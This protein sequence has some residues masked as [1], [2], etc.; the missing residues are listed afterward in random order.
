MNVQSCKTRGL[1]YAVSIAYDSIYSHRTD[2]L[3]DILDIY[4][5]KSFTGK[6]FLEYELAHIYDNINDE[7]NARKYMKLYESHEEGMRLNPAINGVW[8]NH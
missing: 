3:D 2:H 5:W 4:A 6:A 7:E 8:I 1:R